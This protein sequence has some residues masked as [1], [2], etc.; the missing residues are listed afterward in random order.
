LRNWK[1]D[2]SLPR[3][4]R[5]KLKTNWTRHELKRKSRKKKR[6]IELLKLEHDASLARERAALQVESERRTMENQI[7]PARLEEILIRSLPDLVEKM[8]TVQ[9][10]QSI[11]LSSNGSTAPDSV[12]AVAGLVKV[13]KT[14]FNEKPSDKESLI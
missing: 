4:H 7:S 1:R 12:L 13:L 11:H 14:L 3:W 8:P 6:E 9:N 2:E 10:S 5:F